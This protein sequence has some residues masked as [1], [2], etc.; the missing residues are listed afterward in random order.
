MEITIDNFEECLPQVERAIIDCEFMAMDFELTGLFPRSTPSP[1][2]LDTV[3]QRYEACSSACKAFIPIQFG[4][5]TMSWNQ[6]K[7][8][9]EA[10]KFNFYIHPYVPKSGYQ[11]S[12]D[13]SSLKF[14][15]SNQ[16]DFN[17]LFSKGIP[18]ISKQKEQQIFE[19]NTSQERSDIILAPADEEF[20]AKHL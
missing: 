9:Y 17:K 7:S 18:F 8:E 20:L 12:I 16:F 15:I 1:T 3:Q 5:S 14:L 13:L 4:L 6:E 10:K 11:C 2:F 19:Q